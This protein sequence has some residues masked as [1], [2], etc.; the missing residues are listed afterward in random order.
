MN[1]KSNQMIILLKKNNKKMKKKILL[2]LNQ[3]KL[4][5]NLRKNKVEINQI[6]KCTFKKF[7]IT[8]LWNGF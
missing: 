6:T 2:I 7:Y 4:F 5:K 3:K 8:Q 1:Q